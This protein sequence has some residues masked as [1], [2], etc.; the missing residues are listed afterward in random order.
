MYNA[1]YIYTQI[2][3]QGKAKINNGQ[4]VIQLR[5]IRMIFIIYK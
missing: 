1:F 5:V 3:R 2:I 4:V